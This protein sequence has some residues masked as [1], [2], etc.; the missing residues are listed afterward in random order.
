ML[1]KKEEGRENGTSGERPGSPVDHYLLP[2]AHKIDDDALD[3]S[4]ITTTDIIGQEEQMT[5]PDPDRSSVEV[6]ASVQALIEAFGKLPPL[7]SFGGLILIVAIVILSIGGVLPDILLAVPII[8]IVAFL[9]YAYNE[10]RFEFQTRQ[11]ELEY[12]LRKRQQELQY[13]ERMAR[14]RETAGALVFG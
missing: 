11:K 4:R 13:E 14:A 1:G 9:L 10:R 6:Q 7:L 2:D 5:S 12:E 8:A 3:R